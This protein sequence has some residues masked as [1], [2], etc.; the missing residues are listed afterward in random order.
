MLLQMDGASKL[1][2]VAAWAGGGFAGVLVAVA[3]LAF[4]LI[5]PPAYGTGTGAG[6]EAAVEAG[7]AL[8]AAGPAESRLLGVVRSGAP[9][10]AVGA[11]LDAPRVAEADAGRPLSPVNAVATVLVQGSAHGMAASDV[12]SAR[13]RLDVLSQAGQPVP[14]PTPGAAA[15][16]IAILGLLALHRVRSRRRRGL[17]GVRVNGRRP[18]R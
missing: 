11:V 14:A 3:G 9:Q 15:G 7:A 4:A 1:D 17:V 8:E 6:P 5:A 2:R 10:A 18:L 16:G 13:A 12:M